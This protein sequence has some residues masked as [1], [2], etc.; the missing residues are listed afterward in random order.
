MNLISLNLI[1]DMNIYKSIERL[2]YVI[3]YNIGLITHCYE[4]GRRVGIA[5]EN[6]ICTFCN[7]GIGVGLKHYVSVK[8]MMIL[9]LD[10][11]LYKINM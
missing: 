1:N 5:R 6:T 3:D 4:T 10:Q 7:E 2:N 11:S 8:M 9:L